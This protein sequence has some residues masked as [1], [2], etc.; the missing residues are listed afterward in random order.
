MGIFKSKRNG[1]FSQKEANRRQLK[2]QNLIFL[3]GGVIIIAVLILSVISGVSFLAQEINRGVG[4][5][6]QGDINKPELFEIEKFNQIKD[7]ITSPS[8]MEASQ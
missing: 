6:P 8:L 4:I 3:A 1:Y 5:V 7:K 2:R